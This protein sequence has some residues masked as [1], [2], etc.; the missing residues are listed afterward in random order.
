MNDKRHQSKTADHD[1]VLA[2]INDPA[3]T[4][5][6]SPEGVESPEES[7]K[8]APHERIDDRTVLAKIN[9]DD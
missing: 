7:E 9:G 8:N 1:T 5:T 6:E 4:T 2:H 3:P